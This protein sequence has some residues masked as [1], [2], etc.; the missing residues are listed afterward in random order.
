MSY[1]YPITSEAMFE[2]RATQFTGFGIPES[3]VARMRST[4]VDMWLDGP[5]GWVYEWSKLAAGYAEAGDH[6][7]AS[8]TYGCAKFPCLA[9]PQREIALGKQVDEYLTASATFPMHFERR[10]LSIPFGDREVDIPVHLFGPDANYSERPVV[11]V[12][13]GVD[14]W[15]MDL[16][17]MCLSTAQITGATA[18][19]FDLPGT[20]ES[21]GVPMRKSADD[22]VLGIV[23]KAKQLGNGKTGHIALSFGANFSAMTGLRGAVDA[24]VCDGGPVLNA[25]TREHLAHLPF[26]MIDI[27]GNALGFDEKPSLDEAVAAIAELSRR[28]LLDKT[29]NSPMLVVN[30]ADDYFVPQ[31]DTLVFEG[32]KN[33]EVHLIPGTGHVA[34]SKLPEVMPMMLNWLHAELSKQSV[35]D[36]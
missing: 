12:S 34:R 14:T 2:D 26:G 7:L 11:L 21:A 32:R 6:Y 17:R 20:G 35:D 31:S 33:T 3:D 28:E 30:G 8:L 24:S 23:E 15:K 19:A 36:A 18:L 1:T 29:T 25:F 27:V 9:D 10:I 4:I 5:G 22:V 16:H 13:G